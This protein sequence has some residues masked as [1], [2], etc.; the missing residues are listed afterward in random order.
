MRAFASIQH[1]I[2]ASPR[3][4]RL[5]AVGI[6]FALTG[7][8]NGRDRG[9]TTG[10]KRRIYAHVGNTR[11]PPRST[12]RFVTKSSFTTSTAAASRSSR[13]SADDVMSAGKIASY[14]YGDVGKGSAQSRRALSAQVWVSDSSVCALPAAMEAIGL[15]WITPA[16]RISRHRDGQHRTLSR[17][18]NAA[19][20]NNAMSA[21]SAISTRSTS[22]R[23]SPIP[24]TTQ[25]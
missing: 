23:S 6:L 5:A 12:Q 7:N 8:I 25:A 15:T 21:T 2:L 20:E 1:E 11:F 14:G 4:P 10:V 13:S 24:G 18:A 22:P 16:R 3:S 9:T 17:L 19:D